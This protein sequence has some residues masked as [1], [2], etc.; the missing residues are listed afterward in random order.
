MSE[1][2]VEA[3]SRGSRSV[4]RL[5][6]FPF[7]HRKDSNPQSDF[8]PSDILPQDGHRPYPKRPQDELE[9]EQ[10]KGDQPA[11]GAPAGAAASRNGSASPP[12]VFDAP[13]EQHDHDTEPTSQG[14]DEQGAYDLKPPPPSVTHDNIEALAGRLYSADHLD[15][16]LRDQN[17]GPRFIRFLNEFKP[18][19][20]TTLTH[21]LGMKKAITAIQYANALADKIPALPGEAPHIAAKLDEAFEERSQQIVEDLVEEA[22]PAYITHRLVSQVTDVMVKEITGNGTPLMRDLIPSLAE[23]YCISDPSLPDNPLVYASEGTVITCRQ[24]MS[25][26]VANTVPQSFVMLLSMVAT[27]LLAATAAF[28][29]VPRPQIL[30]FNT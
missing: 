18:Q 15:T 10:E 26:A 27:T 24:S 28:S 12:T 11:F 17:S 7:L 4:R 29:K 21:Y 9:D 19:H 20:V 22:L 8:S 16:I 25:N 2:G 6:R 14:S 30:P 1:N 13:D 5:K 3:A 23:V